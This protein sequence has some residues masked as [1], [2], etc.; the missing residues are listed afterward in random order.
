I[1]EKLKRFTDPVTA[2]PVVKEVYDSDRIFHGPYAGDAPDLF[3]GFNPGYRASWRTALGG[4]PDKLIEDNS[5]K[6]SGEHLMDPSLVPGVL[7]MNKKM[8]LSN[9]SIIDI[10][11]TIL[12]LLGIEKPASSFMGKGIISHDKQACPPA[13]A[14]K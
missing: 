4:T 8:D 7:F 11:P 1:T 6:W 5:E 9:P 13:S 12:H 10:A 2:E 14:I 3:V